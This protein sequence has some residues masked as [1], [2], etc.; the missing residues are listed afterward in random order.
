[1]L[2]VEKE[3]HFLEECV[4]VQGLM[5][6]STF[7][8]SYHPCFLTAGALPRSLPVTLANHFGNDIST[9]GPPQM[10]GIAF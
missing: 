10:D 5:G 7:V 8:H 3:G 1:M 2:R 4:A 6:A 9:F